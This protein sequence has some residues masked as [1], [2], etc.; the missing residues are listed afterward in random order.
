MSTVSA[1]FSY[2]YT[3]I[4]GCVGISDWWSSHYSSTVGLE[5]AYIPHTGTVN[6]M[7]GPT[8]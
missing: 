7:A 5:K 8:G 2:S 1:V 4:V 3:A 6:E